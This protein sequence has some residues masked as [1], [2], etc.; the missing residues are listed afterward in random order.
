MKAPYKQ[1]SK[2]IGFYRYVH[3]IW[4]ISKEANAASGGPF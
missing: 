2:S 4:A 1:K 3:V